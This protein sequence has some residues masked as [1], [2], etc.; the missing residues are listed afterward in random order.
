M[1]T[2]LFDAIQYVVPQLHI[3]T[4]KLELQSAFFSAVL[5]G[6]LVSQ[7]WLNSTAAESSR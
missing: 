6:Y 7:I 4:A 5:F 1:L 2:I 3:L